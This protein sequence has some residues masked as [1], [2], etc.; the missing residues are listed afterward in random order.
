MQEKPLGTLYR[1][2]SVLLL[3]VGYRAELANAQY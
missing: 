3:F 2:Y 1:F